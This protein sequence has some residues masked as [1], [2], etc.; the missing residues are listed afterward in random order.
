MNHLDSD[1]FVTCS[2]TGDQFAGRHILADFWDVEQMGDVDFIKEAI[3]ESARK[4]GA[5]IL[6]SYYHPFGKGMGVSG[7]TVLSESHISIHTW[8]ERNFASL[9]IFM[10]GSCDPQ[11]A[12]DYLQ[13]ILNPSSVD[14]S[15]NRRGVIPAIAQIY[16]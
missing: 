15:L 11:D 5:T 13:K 8:P 16:K 2:K 12:L 1:Y 4:A 14:Q 6:H 7:V 9:D 10:C 3:E